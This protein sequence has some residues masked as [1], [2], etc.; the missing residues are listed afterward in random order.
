MIKG[1]RTTVLYTSPVWKHEYLK[2]QILTIEDL[3]KGKRPE[4]P[5]T[6][7]VFQEAPLTQRA[8]KDQQQTLI[9]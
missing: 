6:I 7:G 5:P 8:P 1:T 4:I 9:T 3:L 2:V